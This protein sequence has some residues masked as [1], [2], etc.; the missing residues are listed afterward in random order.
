MCANLD[1]LSVNSENWQQ[2]PS[3]SLTNFIQVWLCDAVLLILNITIYCDKTT[4]VG[5]CHHLFIISV[6][7]VD[8]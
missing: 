4:H 2:Q 7:V 6:H 8:M 5:V 3:A 1:K